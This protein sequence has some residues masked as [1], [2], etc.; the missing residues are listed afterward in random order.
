MKIYR[1]LFLAALMGLLGA[2][3]PFSWIVSPQN[4]E[5]F[6][7]QAWIQKQ[8]HIIKAQAGNINDHVLRLSL[9]AYVNTYKKGLSTSKSLL[10][11]I[12]YSKPSS[13]KRLWVV[14]LAKGRTLFHTW[15]SHG[16]NSGGVNPTSFSNTHSSLKSSIGVFVTDKSYF[17]GNGYS[18]RLRGLERGINDNAYHRNIVVHGAWYVNPDNIRKHGQIGRSWGCPAVSQSLAKPLID[19]IKDRTVV[20]A[21]YP[22]RHWLRNSQ[23]LAST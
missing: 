14:D 11:I 23:F 18:L 12:D 4:R 13:E 22:D 3:W 15:V 16:K 19:T 7:S 2:S 6:G 21:Y 9:I 10:T 8:I 5:A 17:G 20:F 1:L